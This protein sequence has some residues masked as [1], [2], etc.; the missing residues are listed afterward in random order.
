LSRIRIATR[1]SD[2]ALAQADW[3]ARR[4]RERLGVESERVVIETQGDRILDRPLAKIGG[5]GLFVKEIEEALLSGR[6]DVAVHSAKDL[7][8]EVPAGLV[9]AAFPERLDPCD[10]LVTAEPGATLLSLKEGARVGTGSV[11][12]TALLRARRPDLEIVPLRG[13]VPT[14]L[15]KLESEGLDAIVLACAGLL[16]L[17][18]GARIG[19][20]LSPEVMLPAVCQGTLALE[21]CAAGEWA[22][23]I[24][25]LDDAETALRVAAERGL[26]VA[27]EADCSVPLAGLCEVE[28]GD[29]RLRGLLASPMGELISAERRA[30]ADLKHAA[31]AGERVA[32]DLLEAG[33]R[34]LLAELR[35][36]EKA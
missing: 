32:R 34:E 22:E 24:A 23:R 35:A 26:L 15:Q 36:A 27:L 9:L 14:R 12:R 20:R 8:A 30:P 33:G 16:R 2:L 7:P 31:E 13:N 21:V 19:E 11:R 10:A 4:I 5:K 28:G 17:G 6:A 3:T 29:L 18:Q 25:E 1:G